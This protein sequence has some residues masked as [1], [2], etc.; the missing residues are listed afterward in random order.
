MHGPI[1]HQ[2][3]QHWCNSGEDLVPPWWNPLPGPIGQTLTYARRPAARGRVGRPPNEEQ[4]VILHISTND[5]QN[6]IFIGAVE[7]PD[8]FDA[9]QLP[10]LWDDWRADVP[11][12]D[13]DS[14]FIEWLLERHPPRYGDRSGRM[15][16]GFKECEHGIESVVLDV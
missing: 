1:G 6:V 10:G 11:N 8:D 3:P 2:R 7:A 9:K 13:A 15:V 16:A 4:T 12:P 14:E 5:G